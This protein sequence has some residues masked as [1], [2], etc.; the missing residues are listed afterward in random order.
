MSGCQ[1]ESEAGGSSATVR[2]PQIDDPGILMR[3]T[4]VFIIVFF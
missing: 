4:Y 3:H 2:P 1:E